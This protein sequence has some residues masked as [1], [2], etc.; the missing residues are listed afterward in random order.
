MNRNKNN[1]ILFNRC[2]LKRS[3]IKYKKLFNTVYICKYKEYRKPYDSG[4]GE[5]A[6]SR[7]NFPPVETYRRR[8]AS[9]SFDAS[10]L[11]TESAPAPLQPQTDFMSAAAPQAPATNLTGFYSAPVAQ[12]ENPAVD[13]NFYPKTAN[14]IGAYNQSPRDELTRDGQ[15]RDIRFDVDMMNKQV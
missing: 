15:K 12:S 5:K 13:F 1:Y 4:L 9:P 11:N 10:T 7:S 6:V 3:I 8:D 14:T 2:K